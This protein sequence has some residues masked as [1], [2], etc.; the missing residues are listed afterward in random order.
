MLP[1]AEPTSKTFLLKQVHSNFAYQLFFAILFLFPN[2]EFEIIIYF[3]IMFNELLLKGTYA[4]GNKKPKTFPKGTSLA[5]IA[6]TM[7]SGSSHTY[8]Q[9]K[10]TLKKKS[11]STKKPSI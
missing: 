9:N 7:L 3:L 4:F 5:L 8:S 1:E 10:F 2:I 6:A 11:T